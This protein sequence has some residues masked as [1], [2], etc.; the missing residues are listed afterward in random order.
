MIVA[1]TGHRPGKIGEYD[2]YHSKREWIRNRMREELLD[3]RP[4][5]TISGMALGVDQDFAQVSLELTIPFL[6]ALPFI[7]QESRWPKSSQ[8][9]YWWLIE[10]ADDVV[11]VSPGE[12]SAHK[13]QVRNEFMVDHCDILL[14]VWDGSDGGTGNCVKYAQRLIGPALSSSRIRRINPTDFKE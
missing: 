1:V 8:D 9:Y 14:A 5:K 3:L 6:A 13:M 10:R 2:Y 4:T 11:V 12:Y 7:G